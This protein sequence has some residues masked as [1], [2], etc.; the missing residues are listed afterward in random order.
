MFLQES[1]NNSYPSQIKLPRS[2]FFV[3]LQE[4]CILIHIIL[5]KLETGRYS[6]KLLNYIEYS[7]NKLAYFF[8]LLN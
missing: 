6:R 2:Y 1:G 3:S 4:Y 7:I 8:L 5:F